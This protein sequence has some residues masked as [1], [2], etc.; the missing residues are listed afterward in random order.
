[1]FNLPIQTEQAVKEN[2][3]RHKYKNLEIR[4]KKI[5]LTNYRC[6]RSHFNFAK[7]F[8]LNARMQQS[9]RLELSDDQNPSSA[10]I[11][12]IKKA[13]SRDIFYV[14]AKNSCPSS[15]SIA[16][17]EQVHDLSTADPFVKF[18]NWTWFLTT[19]IKTL[20]S[21]L[22]GNAILFFP[23]TSVNMEVMEC[24]LHLHF[25]AHQLLVC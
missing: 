4:L 14:V 3:W 20:F 7:F 13:S 6:N 17:A 11:E 22:G 18:H 25:L 1:M 16:F 5:V 19:T 9:M 12:K 23:Q 8:V 2:T 15:P 10:R 24:N 21:W